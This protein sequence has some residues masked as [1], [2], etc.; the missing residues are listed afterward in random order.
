MSANLK[1]PIDLSMSMAHEN[2]AAQGKYCRRLL[3]AGGLV[4]VLQTECPTRTNVEWKHLRD[5]VL[6]TFR[7]RL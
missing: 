3:I 2:L 5:K 6:Q 1:Y 7:K 4:E